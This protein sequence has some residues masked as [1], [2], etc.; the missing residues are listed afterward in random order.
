MRPWLRLILCRL[1]RHQPLLHMANGRIWLR[2]PECLYETEGWSWTQPPP[3][4]S[5]KVRR[6]KKRLAA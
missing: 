3:A 6:F 5:P 1:R 2:C 4:S